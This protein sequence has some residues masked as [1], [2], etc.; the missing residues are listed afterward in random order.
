MFPT[1]VWSTI[2]QA[3]EHDV[4]A[5]HRFA[6]RYR[7]AILD[8]I[9]RRGFAAGDAEDVCQD[10]FL[11][12]FSSAVLAKAD[13]AR[14]RLRSLLLTITSN[15]ISDHG[16]QTKRQLDIR[17]LQ[18]EPA[19]RDPDFDRAWVLHLAETAMGQ[20]EEEGSSYYQVLRDHLSGQRQDRKQLWH[21]RRKLIAAIR[22]EIAM[23][24]SSY[25]EFE[26]E[27]AYLSPYLRPEK[28]T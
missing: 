23:T 26:E 4:E 22:R 25:R 1:T 28:K 5:L 19:E 11:R 16:R 18:S 8:F 6:E 14:G 12:L 27:V 2:R 20:L 10:V 24:C 15:V 13:P 17:P 3:G 21:A 9:R 7:P